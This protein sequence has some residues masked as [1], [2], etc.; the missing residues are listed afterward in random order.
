[1]RWK[2]DDM[3]SWREKLL[4]FWLRAVLVWRLLKEW[5]KALFSRK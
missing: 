3:A 2:K 5:V 1:M 4:T